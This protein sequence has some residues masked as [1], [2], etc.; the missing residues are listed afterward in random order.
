MIW[1]FRSWVTFL[2][3]LLFIDKKKMLAHVIFGSKLEQKKEEALMRSGSPTL[4]AD[5]S[6][7][8]SLSSSSYFDRAP[9]SGGGGT[10]W[11][12]GE[13]SWPP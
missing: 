2:I 8:P 9:M 5:L 6:S 7:S 1:T 12:A 10:L 3:Y 11:S 4:V 13:V